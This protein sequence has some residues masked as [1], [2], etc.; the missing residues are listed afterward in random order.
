VLP[1]SGTVPSQ[2]D[3]AGCRKPIAAPGLATP[4]MTNNYDQ[5][6]TSQAQPNLLYGCPRRLIYRSCR[7]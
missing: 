3:L 4:T 7:W 5:P 6:G 2:P 1:T